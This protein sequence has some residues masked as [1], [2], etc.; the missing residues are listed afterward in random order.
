M[1]PAT[2]VPLA[3]P[4]VGVS[5]FHAG[6]T[7]V[8]QKM[9]PQHCHGSIMHFLFVEVSDILM[10]EVSASGLER[11]IVS[12]IHPPFLTLCTYRARV[13]TAVPLHGQ[14][15]SQIKK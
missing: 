3:L 4:R 13:L 2:K 10:R 14:P 12:P 11:R 7:K 5:R 6:M 8:K 9:S 1:P 15:F